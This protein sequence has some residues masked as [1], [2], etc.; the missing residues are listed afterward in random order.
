[1]RS[2]AQ[3]SG[4]K[5]VRRRSPCRAGGNLEDHEWRSGSGVANS[6]E[7]ALIRIERLDYG[8][9]ECALPRPGNPM[10]DDLR[11]GRR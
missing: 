9:G 1:M 2:N 4:A 3:V 11:V 8:V 5:T 7:N 6:M 10:K